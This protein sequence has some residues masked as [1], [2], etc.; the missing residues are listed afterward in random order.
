MVVMWTTI[1]QCDTQVVFS[2]KPWNM[3]LKV[4]GQAMEMEE[5][6]NR[7]L[8]YIHRAVLKVSGQDLEN[9]GYV[10]NGT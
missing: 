6:Q 9:I 5:K 4:E 3:S 1:G 7:T 2:D 8:K 10:L